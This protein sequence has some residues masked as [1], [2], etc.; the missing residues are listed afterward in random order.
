MTKKEFR[1]IYAELDE[2][3]AEL[4]KKG[5]AFNLNAVDH[6]TRD[7]YHTGIDTGAEFTALEIENLSAIYL[8]C[9]DTT[10]N[11]NAFLES[12][13][14]TAREFIIEQIRAKGRAN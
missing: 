10:D 13:V 5:I 4:Y 11:L 1:R 14:R 8:S 3:K 2:G 12:V 7:H 9:N 6:R